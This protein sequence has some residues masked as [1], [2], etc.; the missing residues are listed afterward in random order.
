MLYNLAQEAANFIQYLWRY[1][2]IKLVLMYKGKYE[3]MDVSLV[4]SLIVMMQH[5]N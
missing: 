4:E 2:T 1:Y 3:S 5:N